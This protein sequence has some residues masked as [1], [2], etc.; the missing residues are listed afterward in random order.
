VDGLAGWFASLAASSDR[1]PLYYL[2]ALASYEQAPLLFGVLGVL[3][4]RRDALAGQLTFWVLAVLV[5]GSVGQSR[6]IGLTAQ[7]T[8]P[9]ALLAGAYSDRLLRWLADPGSRRGLLAFVLGSIVVLAGFGIA[10]SVFSTPDPPVTELLLAIPI[11]LIALCLAYSVMANGVSRTARFGLVVA[12]AVGVLWGWRENSML[13]YGSGANPAQLLVETATS[14][15]V[16]QL[17]RDVNDI[18]DAFA[19]DGRQPGV[20]VSP[21]LSSS[22]RWYLR[23]NPYVGVGDVP[24]SSTVV[25]VLPVGEDDDEGPAGYVGQRYRVDTTGVAEINSWKSFWRWYGYRE[26]LD[27]GQPTDAMVYVR[28]IG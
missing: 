18:S 26:A 17:A 9:L 4:L 12:L 28:P 5:L 22:V 25:Q 14:P 7:I 11:A 8:I 2:A 24:R 13:S 23:D 1:S 21:A 20:L 16:R 3:A 15:D 27:P 10:L 6:P 19:N